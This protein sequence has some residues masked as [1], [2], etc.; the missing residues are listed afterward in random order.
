ML[1][2]NF[3][4]ILIFCLAVLCH[5]CTASSVTPEMFGAVGDGVADDRLAIE[6]A[7]NSSKKVEFS[8][9]KTYRI[10]SRFDGVSIF[11][12]NH[13]LELDGNGATLLLDTGVTNRVQRHQMTILFFEDRDVDIESVSYKDLNIDVKVSEIFDGPSIPKKT[14]DGNFYLFTINSHQQSFER[15][16]VLNNGKRNNMNVITVEKCDDL[17]LKKCHFSNC[18]AS[19]RGGMVWTMLADQAKGKIMTANIFDCEFI[20]DTQDEMICFASLKTNTKDCNISFNIKDCVFKS[21]NSVKGSAFVI[22]YD[23]RNEGIYAYDAN[24]VFKN[25][26]F[27]SLANK[28]NPMIDRPLIIPQQSSSSNCSWNLTFDHC[29][30]DYKNELS[31]VHNDNGK[32]YNSYCIG[33]MNM[34]MKDYQR[35]NVLMNNCSI[36]TNNGIIDGYRGGCAGNITLKNCDIAC[37]AIRLGN[38]NAESAVANI[39]VEDCQVTTKFPYSCGANEVWRE[40]RIVSPFESDFYVCCDLRKQ[41]NKV[42]EKCTFN[43]R[44]IE[45]DCQ[46]ESGVV[47]RAKYAKYVYRSYGGK[48]LSVYGWV[49]K[50]HSRKNEINTI[51]YKNDDEKR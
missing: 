38:A 32:W 50:S 26:S 5:S 20:Q 9:N 49:T 7:I 6:K 28:A 10:N 36:R 12:I 40:N 2:L 14:N 13:K 11:R 19:L 4:F 23:I 33:V 37:A 47:K 24:G 15:I 44:L 18:S 48:Y 30:I 22:C 27:I 46:R 16:N 45:V 8:R 21:L 31:Q 1:K 39:V 41:Q 34:S 42:F 3:K 43:G 51:E 25:C 29:N 35:Y 17:I